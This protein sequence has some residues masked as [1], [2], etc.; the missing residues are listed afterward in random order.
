MYLL[1]ENFVRHWRGKRVLVI[2]DAMLDVDMPV[3]SDRPSP[4][5][6]GGRVWRVSEGSTAAGGAAN[7]AVNLKAMGA[8]PHL[9]AVVGADTNAH[10]LGACLVDD[11]VRSSLVDDW[12]R[13]TTIKM[14]MGRQ[15]RMDCESTRLLPE[16]VA[17]QVRHAILD[18]ATY[19][20]AII[21]SDYGKGVLCPSVKAALAKADLGTPCPV[22]LDPKHV[23]H[24]Q[25]AG[26][27]SHVTPN[28]G[29]LRAMTETWFGRLAKHVLQHNLGGAEVVLTRGNQ[30]AKVG[31][32][33]I[34]TEPV[35]EPDVRGAG[36]TF[37]AAFTLALT[38]GATVKAAALMGNAAA[39]QAVLTPG[40]TA[41]TAADV[42]L[43]LP[44]VAIRNQGLLLL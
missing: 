19:A 29:E 24:K 11:D 44:Y 7:V 23:L 31:A 4:E 39:R 28:L 5:Y 2:G 14:R 10:N 38:V 9:I 18:R 8:D 26:I 15:V 41:V 1:L 35:K 30:G 3:D 34:Y 16:K 12:D 21:L 33:A 6:K 40:T 13:P 25:L 27:V 32:D 22:V 36:D 43:Q 42:L 17:R 37:V 20:D